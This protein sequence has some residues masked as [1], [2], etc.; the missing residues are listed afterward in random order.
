M[1]VLATT[2]EFSIPQFLDA[3]SACCDFVGARR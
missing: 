2:C 3:A 1:T